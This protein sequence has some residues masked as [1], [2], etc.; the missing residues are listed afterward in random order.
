MH[1]DSAMRLAIDTRLRELE[2]SENLDAFRDRWRSATLY[3]SDTS[4]DV[5]FEEIVSSHLGIP[6]KGT[7]EERAVYLEV[8]GSAI[9][10]MSLQ[11]RRERTIEVEDETSI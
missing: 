4:H 1:L 8:T 6:R 2:N 7:K 11:R 5:Q 3:T 9:H 10:I